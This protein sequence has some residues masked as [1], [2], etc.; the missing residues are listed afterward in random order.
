MLGWELPPF[1][2][3]GLGVACEGLTRSLAKNGVDL[4]FVL[5]KVYG[6]DN[7]WMRVYDASGQVLQSEFSHRCVELAKK[8]RCSLVNGYQSI[9]FKKETMKLCRYCT[10]SFDDSPYSHINVYSRGVAAI[11]A[12]LDYDIIHAHDWMTYR[13]GVVARDVAQAKGKKVPFLAQV[14][15]TEIDRHDGAFIYEAEKTGFED[16][17]HIVAVSRL[18]KKT[19]VDYYS[20]PENKI[21]VVHNGIDPREVPVFG[22][23]PFK[24]KYKVVLYLGRITYQK[25]PDYFVKVAKLV[26]KEFKNV[27]FMM[28]GSGD[29]QARMI[30]LGAREGLT[31][32]LLFNSWIKEHEKDLAYQIADVFVM[33]S[34]S[35]PF[36][37]VPLEAIQNGTPIV[38]SKSSGVAEVI[39][40]SATVDFWDLNKM[41]HEIVKLLSDK[42][43]SKKMVKAAQAEVKNLTWDKS[44]K[45]MI[46]VYESVLAGQIKGE[47][48]HA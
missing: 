5:P 11:A 17:N 26:I 6:G 18:T 3:G 41:A 36:G 46:K 33:P 44:S 15:A 42:D 2:S 10:K 23:N 31:G 9:V 21:S 45:E 43:Y 34:V 48:T 29:M 16:A 22:K 25:G 13:A 28:L 4:D 20:I 19:V 12:R 8:N 1:H 14:H 27:K 35:E 7:S 32:K 38:V 37:I 40:S 47:R 24:N 39:S 30:E